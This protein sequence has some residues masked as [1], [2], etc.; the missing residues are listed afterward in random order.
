M[1]P[2]IQTL[3]TTVRCA[4][5]KNTIHEFSHAFGYLSDEYINGRDTKNGGRDK[6]KRLNP[7]VPSV[8]TCS[9]L[10]YSDLDTSVPWLH[11]APTGR[12]RRS[13]GGTIHRR[14]PAGC[15]SVATFAEGV[16]HSEY[17]CLMNGNHDNFAFTQETANDPTATGKGT[18]VDENGADL[19]DGS[20]FCAWC[21]EIVALRILERTD[22]FVQ[23][24]DPADFTLLG[25]V[26]FG[27]W[28][29]LRENYYDLLGVEQ[30]II[31]AEA[32]FAAMTPGASREPLWQS[33]LYRVPAAAFA[34]PAGPV[35]ALT[36]E[37][38]Y[39]LTG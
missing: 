14:W 23:P 33:D 37:E 19:R 25:Q 35:T 5:G 21:Q 18:Y 30:Q 1:F 17:C 29:G 16:W 9:N 34:S 38:T 24:S 10:S 13:A 6:P 3:P 28:Q 22:Q 12:F 2:A 8:F 20:R 36:D 27:R 7:T 31:D 26:W 32:A 39:L 4:F 15:G 11:L